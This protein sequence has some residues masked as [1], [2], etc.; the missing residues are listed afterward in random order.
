[1]R[2]N[3]HTKIIFPTSKLGF[4]KTKKILK[5]RVYLRPITLK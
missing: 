3:Q 1:M 4:S 5:I 2:K